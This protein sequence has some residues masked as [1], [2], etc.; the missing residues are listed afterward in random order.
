L[1]AHPGGIAAGVSALRLSWSA[2]IA[3][4]PLDVAAKTHRELREA[5]EK[6]A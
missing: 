6:F 3:G 4:V 2:A 1:F 5:L